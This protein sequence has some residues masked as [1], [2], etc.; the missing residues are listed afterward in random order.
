L[1]SYFQ[2]TNASLLDFYSSS[3]PEANKPVFSIL[4]TKYI[5]DYHKDGF[6]CTCETFLSY[7]QRD[8]FVN[9]DFHEVFVENDDQ[10]S[11]QPV[12]SPQQLIINI[13]DQL[14]FLTYDDFH[15]YM[16]L[17]FGQ[18]K[19]DELREQLNMFSFSSNDTLTTPVVPT[20][21]I[22]G[23]NLLPF[24]FYD[25]FSLKAT[26][27][28]YAQAINQ[29]L[30]HKFVAQN[31]YEDQDVFENITVDVGNNTIAAFSIASNSSSS[32]GISTLNLKGRIATFS[33]FIFG[34]QK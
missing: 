24:D 31:F 27:D 7:E 9:D 12:A 17:N 11:K 13:E 18:E 21:G 23:S 25:A 1:G 2:H 32:D 16:C 30:Q 29:Q 10:F 14:T 20:P 15:N 6:T 26:E 34:S 22:N 28:I 8:E 5:D 4:E 19:E 33:H 3:N